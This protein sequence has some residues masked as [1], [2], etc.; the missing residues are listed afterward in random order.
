MLGGLGLGVA[1]RGAEYLEEGARAMERGVEVSPEDYAAG[2]FGAGLIGATEALPVAR[3]LRLL[4]PIKKDVLKDP[5]ALD[6]VMGYLKEVGL[7]A[8]AEALQE[9]GAGLLM[10][11]NLQKYIDPDIEVGESFLDDAAAGGFAGAVIEG[12]IGLVPGARR[13]VSSRKFAEE[14]ERALR[15]LEEIE[16]ANDAERMSQQLEAEAPIKF[17]DGAPIAQDAIDAAIDLD[18]RAGYSGAA[19]QIAR[20]MGDA[21]PT[22]P[23]FSTFENT[24]GT[25]S[26]VGTE[27]DGI[28]ENKRVYA[29]VPAEK[30]TRL[31]PFVHALNARTSQERLYQ[32]NEIVFDESGETYSQGQRKTLHRIGRSVLGPAQSTYS[33]DA[34]N[35]AG[36]TT[37]ER[38]FQ[39]ELTAEEVIDQK[40][41]ARQQ[42]VAQKINVKRLKKNLPETNRFTIAEVQSVLGEDTG[43]LAEFISG[44][45]EAETYRAINVNGDP[46]ISVDQ[47]GN[48]IA[49]INDRPTT[50]AERQADR[51]AGRRVRYRTKFTSP[52]DA[53]DY[54]GFINSQKGGAF[55]P[56]KELFGDF[57]LGRS[58]IAA[59]LNAKNIT[60]DVGSKE[61]KKLAQLLTGRKLRRDQ[62]LNSLSNAELQLFY[63]K[64]RQLPRFESPTKLPFF[65]I[66]PY[67]KKQIQELAQYR[68]DEGVDMD[69]MLFNGRYGPTTTADYNRAVAAAR[70]LAGVEPIAALP[71][72]S[73]PSGMS[74]TEKDTLEKALNDRLQSLGLS[75]IKGVITNL[76]RHR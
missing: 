19:I 14:E 13:T 66:K 49:V 35:Y 59:L 47:Q 60:S 15:E 51:E 27:F 58:E 5:K 44:V 20:S 30:A 67:T 18:S 32:N 4:R 2:K 37:A 17:D 73:M 22:E 6:K 12:M 28:S 33:S 43:N 10:D 7:G 63:H 26:L 16:A 45:S 50:K 21:F 61:I 55:L 75:D 25:I 40:I 72:P 71:S 64:L 70:D 1:S 11:V 57:K 54:A 31:A 52:K 68:R 76:V 3:A 65:E 34:V 69:E 38:G 36:N 56:S 8:G 53:Q 29:T 41:P 74:V 23:V 48:Q 62:G 39:E 24:D 46:A 9:S 42:T